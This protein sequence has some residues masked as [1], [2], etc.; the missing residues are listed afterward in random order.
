MEDHFQEVVCLIRFGKAGELFV[1]GKQFNQ[2]MHGVT[3]LTDI[4]IAEITTYIYNTWSHERGLIDVT[5][6]SKILAGC[7]GAGDK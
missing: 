4:E 2:P 6:T 3:S 1:N 7:Q 5:E